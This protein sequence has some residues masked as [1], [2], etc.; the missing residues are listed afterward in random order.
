MV[1]RHPFG[2]MLCFLERCAAYQGLLS[3]MSL[4][5]PGFLQSTDCYFLLLFHGGTRGT[6][7]SSVSSIK[8]D[9]RPLGLAMRHSG[10][11]SF[12]G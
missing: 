6:A 10:A 4:R 2:D 3:G 7:R 9:Y 8:G 11:A 12:C 5:L 1:Q